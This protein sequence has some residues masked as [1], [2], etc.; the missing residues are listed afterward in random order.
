MTRTGSCWSDRSPITQVL[1][2]RDAFHLADEPVELGAQ[3]PQAGTAGSRGHAP[4]RER[5]VEPRREIGH[6]GARADKGHLPDDHQPQLRQ[7]VEMG[8]PDEATEPAV[9]RGEQVV[10]RRVLRGVGR[11]RPDLRKRE[12]TAIEADSFLAEQRRGAEHQ[13]RQAREHQHQRQRDHERHEREHELEAARGPRTTR[14][15]DPAN[16]RGVAS[17]VVPHTGTIDSSPRK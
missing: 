8:T 17:T 15:V 3:L 2:A 4:A 10:L 14:P 1:F 16:G 12:P 7:L 6:F 11:Q 5:R 9:L 13:G